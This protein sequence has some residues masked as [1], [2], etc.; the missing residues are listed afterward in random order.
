MKTLLALCLAV[1]LFSCSATDQ[2]VYSVTDSVAGPQLRDSAEKPTGIPR[3]QVSV[4]DTASAT[5]MPVINTA[6]TTA[7][8][9]VDYAQSLLGVPYV[10]ASA[11][12]AKGFDC[13]GFV[14][15]VFGHFHITVPRSS[16]DFTYVGKTIPV[17]D[18][19]KGD[20]IL[21][22]GTDSSEK[23]VGH[24]GLVVSN[25]PGDLRFIHATSGRE[26]A[27]AISSLTPRYRKRFVRI[28]R[29]FP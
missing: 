12:P 6:L 9:L 24:M 10:Y 17:D 27:V 13:S 25:Q 26:M 29:I 8:E 21:F 20:I 4:T 23:E 2:R 22:T 18:A 28:G 11:D 15:Y 16:V 5:G 1:W 14:T 19:R 7:D 3:L